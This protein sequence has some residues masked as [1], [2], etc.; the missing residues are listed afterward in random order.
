MYQ[1]LIIEDDKLLA[2]TLSDCFEKQLYHISVITDG[3]VGYKKALG[4]TFDIL[5]IDWLLPNKNGVDIIKSLRNNHIDTP[6]LIMS[7]KNHVNEIVTG[8]KSGSDGYICK[9][10][11]LL[12]FKTRVLAL[13][14]RP[15]HSRKS[16]LTY[17]NISID[18]TRMQAFI[19]HN[20]CNLR[21]KELLI[22]QFLLEHPDMN[23]TREQILNNV[24]GFEAD[25][26]ESSID[27]H[28]SRLRGK[29]DKP[30]GTHYIKTIH[31]FGYRL[32]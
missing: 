10:F 12:E 14:L 18:L 28:I 6:T 5:V 9:P 13:L 27:V 4:N 2:E 26:Y 24:W 29:V 25:P 20:E 23:I 17:K 31:G 11:N 15:S 22:L 3:Q 19:G 32:S 1:I 21:K 16:Y 8:L 30:F 7:S